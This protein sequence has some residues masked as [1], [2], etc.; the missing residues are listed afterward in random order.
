[1]SFSWIIPISIFAGW[2]VNVVADTVPARRSIQETWYWPFQHIANV[3]RSPAHSDNA[4]EAAAEPS[5]GS[6]A[7]YTTVWILAIAL[8]G[9]SVMRAGG[10]SEAMVL[11][12]Y[13]W[14]LL[15]IGVIDI[16]HRL[17]LNRMLL[18]ALPVVIIGN[19]VAGL[20]TLTSSIIGGIVGFGLFL[21]IALI[22]P[23][24]MG[25]GDVKLAGVIGLATGIPGIL[26][27]VLVCIFSGGLAALFILAR[28]R[29]QRGQT[30]A[31]A[32]YLVLGAWATLYFGTDLW[33]M[34]MQ[35]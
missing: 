16:E 19:L 5:R 25:M 13:A 33:R 3:F 18:P 21:L 10:L 32:P 24:S 30:M 22:K 6:T 2:V 1:M 28:S 34:Y 14:F 9:L 15:G 17:V 23:G 35:L 20:P 7:R 29:F 12:I 31:Y 8:G 4:P 11:A 26:V 27:T